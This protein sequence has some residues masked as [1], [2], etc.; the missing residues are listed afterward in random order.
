MSCNCKNGS[1]EIDFLTLVPGGTAANATYQLSLTHYLCGNK[2][3][4]ASSHY[5]VSA[6]LQYKVLGTPQDVG[7]GSYCCD[8]LC[9]GTCT[10][11]PYK[12]GCGN[13]CCENSQCPVTENIYFTM[14]V[15]CPSAAVPTITGGE[16]LATPT[17]LT[18]CCSVTN[19]VAVST[20][21]NVSTAAAQTT[22]A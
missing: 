4:C 3:V 2:K 21:F 8:V 6:N 19:A 1:T 7:N 11:M 15:P 16:V 22:G 18:D 10:Y 5:P 14:C 13:Q 12:K 9:T 17:N 20:S